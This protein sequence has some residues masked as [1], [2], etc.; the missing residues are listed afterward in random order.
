MPVEFMKEDNPGN[1]TAYY[2]KDGKRVM[3]D[4]SDKQFKP[5]AI[6]VVNNSDI[7][8]SLKCQKWRNDGECLYDV[9]LW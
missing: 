5:A 2:T 7:P 9:M 3:T 4:V 8:E 6:S 1:K